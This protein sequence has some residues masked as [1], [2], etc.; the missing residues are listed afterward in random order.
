MQF[1]I[2]ISV[3]KIALIVNFFEPAVLKWQASLLGWLAFMFCNTIYSKNEYFTHIAFW[4]KNGQNILAA[5]LTIAI[6]HP[7]W[8][9]FVN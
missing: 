7:E 5:L 3:R 1:L 8:L 4:Y 6:L 9:R 2:F